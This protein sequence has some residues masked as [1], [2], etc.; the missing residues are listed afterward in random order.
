MHYLKYLNRRRR[1]FHH[2]SKVQE[3]SERPQG[4]V[5]LC[6]IDGGETATLERKVY[7]NTALHIP[8]VVL[9]GLR[10]RRYVPWISGYDD[11]GPE[12]VFFNAWYTN[13]VSSWLES[14]YQSLTDI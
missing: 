5:L 11:S 13:T 9:F 7:T 12:C 14:G 10:E 2:L 6:L 3:T 4:W 1:P 8:I